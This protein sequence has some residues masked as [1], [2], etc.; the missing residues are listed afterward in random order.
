MG[1]RSEILVTLFK[2]SKNNCR[3]FDPPQGEKSPIIDTFYY[4][5]DF[6]SFA[7]EVVE[8]TNQFNRFT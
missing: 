1:K 7:S 3:H 4:S 6:S 8:M 2:Q 5:G